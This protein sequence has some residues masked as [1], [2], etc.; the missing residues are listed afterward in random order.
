MNKVLSACIVAALALSHPFANAS[1]LGVSPTKEWSNRV[2]DSAYY[3]GPSGP[4]QGKV[5]GNSDGINPAYEPTNVYSQ[6]SEV[7]TLPNEEQDA[8]LTSAVLTFTETIPNYNRYGLGVYGVGL[9]THYSIQ[10]SLWYSRNPNNV[11]LGQ[12]PKDYG[13]DVVVQIDVTDYLN[14][15]Y[16]AGST[17][18]FVVRS[19]HEGQDYSPDSASFGVQSMGLTFTPNAPATPAQAVPEPDG[20]AVFV[21]GLALLGCS[22]R[23]RR[24]KNQ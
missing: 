15:I 3:Y 13:R 6:L 4:A 7:Y 17:V 14:S 21:S 8:T 22:L 9:V 1:V 16:S 12:L 20:T 19:M 2:S 5:A 24:K 10:T 23:L 11:L 18:G